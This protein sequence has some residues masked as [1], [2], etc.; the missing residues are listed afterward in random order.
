MTGPEWSVPVLSALLVRG[1]RSCDALV[2]VGR[3]RFEHYAR[4][5]WRAAIAS[6]VAA[7]PAR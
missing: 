4:A 5:D 6:Y 1:A 2:D 3:K 7:V